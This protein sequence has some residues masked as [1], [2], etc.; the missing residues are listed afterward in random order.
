MINQQYIPQTPKDYLKIITII[1]LGLFAGI[2]LF[3][4]AAFAITPQKGMILDASNVFVLVV[5]IVAIMGIAF[6]VVLYK[7]QL[8]A[9]IAKPTLKEKLMN[10]QTAFIMRFA[11]LEGAAMFSIV[12]YLKTGNLF[13]LVITA[14][15][16]A[17]FL[18]FRPTKDRICNDLNLGYDEQTDFNSSN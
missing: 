15:M 14:V 18:I 4:V 5:P 2:L 1:Y 8:K 7:Q 12:A 11:A 13:C 10:Y 17:I 9:A 6:S 16:L 3:S